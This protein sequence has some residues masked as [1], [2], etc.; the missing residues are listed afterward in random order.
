M[1][2]WRQK[3]V[4]IYRYVKQLKDFTV[5]YCLFTGHNKLNKRHSH[6]KHIMYAWQIEVTVIAY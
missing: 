6:Q 5:Y 2:K 3:D 1:K 4:D